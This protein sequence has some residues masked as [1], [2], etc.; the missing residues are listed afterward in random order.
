MDSKLKILSHLA[1][2]HNILHENTLSTI[3]KW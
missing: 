3:G 1:F 2:E